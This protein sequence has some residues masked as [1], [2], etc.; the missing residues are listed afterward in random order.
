MNKSCNQ[1]SYE[2]YL[3]NV[4]QDGEELFKLKGWDVQHHYGKI[5]VV[6]SDGKSYHICDKREGK[7]DY[8]KEIWD[9][10]SKAMELG[11]FHSDTPIGGSLISKDE[12]SEV[13][14]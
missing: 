4:K 12:S 8:S 2:Y 14:Q 5:T 3:E 13:P 7:T 10:Y 1:D 11:L 6:G 9:S